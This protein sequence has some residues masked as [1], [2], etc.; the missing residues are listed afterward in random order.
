MPD[1][2]F[3]YIDDYA[4]AVKFYKLAPRAKSKKRPQKEIDREKYITET[5]EALASLTADMYRLR[6]DFI[7]GLNVTA[8][9]IET[10]LSGAVTAGVMHVCSYMGTSPARIYEELEI[11]TEPYDTKAERTVRS[12][13][14]CSSS[15]YPVIIHTLFG[16]KSDNGYFKA[17]YNSFPKHTENYKLDLLYDWLIKLGYEMSDVEKDLMHG[18]HELFIDKDEE[19]CADEAL[20]AVPLA[21]TNT[22]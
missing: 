16:D 9:N 21:T 11:E 13:A 14:V 17:Y 1:K 15:S 20:E 12:A 5:R 7:S 19:Q 10:I 8:K 18:T 6:C 3:Y 4:G 22:D 2:L